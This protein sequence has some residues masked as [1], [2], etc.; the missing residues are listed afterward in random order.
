M[1]NPREPKPLKTRAIVFGA[2]LGIAG[3]IGAAS[4]LPFTTHRDVHQAC[5][6][7][8]SRDGTDACTR[9]QVG[10][11]QNPSQEATNVPIP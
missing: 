3:V 1:K 10:S 11:V 5:Q 6:D 4:I 7:R 2:G 9:S 8:I